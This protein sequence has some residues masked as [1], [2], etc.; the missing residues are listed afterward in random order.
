MPPLVV[1]EGGGATPGGTRASKNA[2]RKRR[3]SCI[4]TKISRLL[5]LSLAL[6]LEVEVEVEVAVVWAKVAVS[7]C[8]VRARLRVTCRRSSWS[9]WDGML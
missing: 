6:A 8:R 2:P 3:K 7:A 9:T 1:L 5:A 4:S